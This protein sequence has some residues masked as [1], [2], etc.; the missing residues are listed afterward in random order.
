MGN[1]LRDALL[2]SGAIKPEDTQ[3]AKLERRW[4]ERQAQDEA[5]LAERESAP[6]PPAWEAPPAGKIVDSRADHPPAEARA[7]C[8]DCGEWFDLISSADRPY[9]RSD[10]CGACAQEGKTTL[11]PEELAARRR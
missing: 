6:P 4:R 1:S 5:E 2:K 10:Q 11:T 9:G 3:E 7:I 8:S